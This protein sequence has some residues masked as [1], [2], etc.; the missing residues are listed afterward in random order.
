MNFLQLHSPLFFLALFGGSS[1]FVPD[2]FAE[3]Q[4]PIERADIKISLVDDSGQESSVYTLAP[5][6]ESGNDILFRAAT[7]AN[8]PYTF[9]TLDITSAKSGQNYRLALSGRAPAVVHWDGVFSS[10]GALKANETY[11]VRLLLVSEDKKVYTSPIVAFST[12]QGTGTEYMQVERKKMSFYAF[13]TG[14]LYYTALVTKGPSSTHF[15]TMQ[16][17]LRLAFDDTHS[18]G[19]IVETSPNILTNVAITPTGFFYSHISLFY[20]YRLF[21]SLPHP[22]ILPITPD[23]AKGK[24]APVSLPAKAF[25]AKSNLEVGFRLYSNVLR[26]FGNQDIDGYLSRQSAGVIASIVGDRRVG[27]F[28]AS[29]T[30]ELGYSVFKGS[31]LYGQARAGFAY[32]RLEHLSPGIEARYILMTGGGADDLFDNTPTGGPQGVMNHVIMAG[33][34]VQFKI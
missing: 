6:S 16:A 24:G 34:F 4:D 15:P 22:P 12:K 23:Y 25:G 9:W 14:A 1:A 11:Y 13:P 3:R 8:L 7:P 31:L 32:D 33:M 17:S 18:F 30:L 26:G 10:G 2:A 5:S 29:G 28:R 19:F 20:L 27:A 21:G